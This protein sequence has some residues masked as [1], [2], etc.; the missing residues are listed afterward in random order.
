MTGEGNSHVGRGLASSATGNTRSRMGHVECS[1]GVFS[2]R[3][4]E[5]ALHEDM[6]AKKEDSRSQGRS[7]EDA[8]QG[9]AN[10][11][12]TTTG[13]SGSESDQGDEGGPSTGSQR[14]APAARPMPTTAAKD[15]MAGLTQCMHLL[16]KPYTVL[17]LG[18]RIRTSCFE[19]GA[20]DC[21]SI[22]GR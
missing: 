7:E 5:E 19:Q 18:K 16:S 22:H 1:C 10:L 13:A 14:C 2:L 4:Q 21:C 9:G 12:G 6:E 20:R 3:M 11:S 17:R 8:G 15:L